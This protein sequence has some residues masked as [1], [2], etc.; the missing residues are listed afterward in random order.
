M[1][2]HR[3]HSSK[4]RRRVQSL[5]ALVALGCLGFV[6]ACEESPTQVAADALAP[7]FAPGGNKGK[8]GGNTNDCGFTPLSITFGNAGDA[9]FS[10]GG[11]DAGEYIEG[12]D[13]GVH[14]NGATGRL[15]LWTS[16]YDDP[17][18]W[19][20]V[21]TLEPFDGPTTDRIYTNSHIPVTD[22]C[23]FKDIGPGL[24]GTAVLEVELD[25][26]GIVR[27]GEP[28][29]EDSPAST[30]V[31]VIRSSDVSWTVEGTSGVHCR[32]NGLRGKKAQ[33]DHVGTAGPFFMTL[34]PPPSS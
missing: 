13:G 27:Y 30:R 25:A 5:G 4:I 2:P 17:I 16:Q 28:C 19:V 11:G 21:S 18:R 29:N 26:D 31:T 7:Q 14:L 3:N 6:A 8:P 20:N 32:S 33:L 22:G 24:T 34:Q 12:R 9:L 10:D 23:G 1:S 15:M